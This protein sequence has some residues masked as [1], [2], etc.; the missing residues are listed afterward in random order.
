MPGPAKRAAITLTLT[1]SGYFDIRGLVVVFEQAIQRFEAAQGPG[2]SK[3]S[4]PRDR[5]REALFEALNWASSIELLLRTGPSA[6]GGDHSWETNLSAS[7]ADIVDAITHARGAVHHQWWSA[8]GLHVV[9]SGAGK[10]PSN[11][12]IWIRLPPRT[13]RN[14]PDGRQAYER[15]LKG[16]PVIEAINVLRKVFGDELARNPLPERLYI[17]TA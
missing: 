10:P 15:T 16:R 14:D 9:P 3:A 2:L 5:A 13:N 11:T 12:W 7:E 6:R 1:D 8:M 17:T 4:A